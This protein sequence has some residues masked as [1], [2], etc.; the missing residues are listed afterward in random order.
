MNAEPQASWKNN[1]PLTMCVSKWKHLRIYVIEK[2]QM[3]PV[4]QLSNI[5]L[6]RSAR[7]AILLRP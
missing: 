7:R 3:S 2:L 1:I 4:D 6:T 5:Q